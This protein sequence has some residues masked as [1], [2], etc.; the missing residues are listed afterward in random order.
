MVFTGEQ[1]FIGN[2]RLGALFN[3]ICSRMRSSTTSKFWELYE[4]FP[5]ATTLV[6]ILITLFRWVGWRPGGNINTSI[7]IEI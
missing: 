1:L 6:A 4:I 2:F 3:D 7:V 5:A